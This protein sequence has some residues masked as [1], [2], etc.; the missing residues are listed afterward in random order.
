MEIFHTLLLIC[1]SH[2]WQL[3][4]LQGGR[5]RAEH[6]SENNVKQG[7]RLESKLDTG[8]ALGSSLESLM[9]I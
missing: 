9:T 6:C 1:F 4:Q 2:L 8:L 7:E 5:G 3:M